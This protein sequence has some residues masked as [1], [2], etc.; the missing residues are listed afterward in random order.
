M[1]YAVRICGN[2]NHER[3]MRPIDFI[4]EFT[5]DNED[6]GVPLERKTRA[7]IEKALE[8]HGLYGAGW[9]EIIEID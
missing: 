5:K 8:G 1:F 2:P 4:V 6:D 9:V 3:Y 7:E